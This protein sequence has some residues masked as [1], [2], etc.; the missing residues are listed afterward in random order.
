MIQRFTD[1]RAWQE[2]HTLVLAI[3]RAT[4]DFPGEEAFGLT[5][6]MRRASV[7]VPSN[8]AEGFA[9]Q[10]RKDKINFYTTALASLSELRSQLLIARDLQY[11]PPNHFS[12]LELQSDTVA[13]LLSGLIRTA[14]GK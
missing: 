10:T 2:A 9:R 12:E 11:V 5:S 1:L 14:P 8:I 4:Q 6:Q 7:S 3:Y 13:Q